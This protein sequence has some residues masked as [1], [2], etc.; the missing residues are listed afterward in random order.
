MCVF[1]DL[2]PNLDFPSSLFPRFCCIGTNLHLWCQNSDES[3]SISHTLGFYYERTEWKDTEW[4]QATK[5]QFLMNGFI[6]KT[7]SI[8]HRVFMSNSSEVWRQIFSV[9]EQKISYKPMA[10]WNISLSSNKCSYTSKLLHING[11]GLQWVLLSWFKFIPTTA[12]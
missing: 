4:R 12:S 2:R 7:G 6:L 10:Q 5:V 3:R 8:K 11:F 9:S 1:L